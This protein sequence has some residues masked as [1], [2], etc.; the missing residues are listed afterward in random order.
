MRRIAYSA[1]W[2]LLFTIPW[3][4]TL[5][6]DSVGTVAKAVGWIVGAIG[7]FIVLLENRMRLPLWLQCG[8][9][10]V[11]WAWLSGIWSLDRESTLIRALTYTQLWIMAW[12]IYQYAEYLDQL[13]MAYVLGACVAAG[14]TLYAFSQGMQAAY[15]RFAAQGFDPNDLSIYLVLAIVLSSYLIAKTSSPLLKTVCIGYI[16]FAVITVI[17]TGSRTGTI[18]LA[19]ALVAMISAVRRLDWRWKLAVIVLG[20][21]SG[22]ISASFVPPESLSRIATL[23]SEIREGTWNIR[24]LIWEAGLTLFG[25]HPVLGVG[26]GAF[27]TAVNPLVHQPA[28]PHNVFIAVAVEGGIPALFLWVGFILGAFRKVLGSE[29]TEKWAWIGVALVLATAFLALNFEWR[30]TTWAMTALAAGAGRQGV[31][32]GG[33]KRAEE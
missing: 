24:L 10:F 9:V 19:V 22:A 17:L 7:L 31:V 30:K 27:R 6:L 33:E 23:A 32:G 29:H 3:E 15:L 28:A 20:A 21:A 13:L 12:L 26:A 8:L 11:C 14:M 25:E 2:A 5:V 16:P 1:I 18:A 4:N